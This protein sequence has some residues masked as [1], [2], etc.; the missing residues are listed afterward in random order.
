MGKSPVG[1]VERLHRLLLEIHETA[2]AG[3]PCPTFGDLCGSPRKGES[4]AQRVLSRFNFVLPADSART[5][6]LHTRWRCTVVQLCA[7]QPVLWTCVGVVVAWAR[8]HSRI[9]DPS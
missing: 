2:V 6:C 9:T 1:R 4:G 8:R 7:C 3:P 5:S